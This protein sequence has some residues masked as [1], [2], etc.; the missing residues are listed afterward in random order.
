VSRPDEQAQQPIGSE[1]T[2]EST[3]PEPTDADR[4]DS[5][6]PEHDPSG[7]DLARSVAGSYR[8]DRPRKPRR[9]RRRGRP[10]SPGSQASGAYPDD[11][12]PQSLDASIDRLV[13]EHGWQTDI[14]VHA[15]FARWDQIVGVEVAQHCTP[16]RYADDELTV[17]ADSTSWA[18]QMRLLAADVVRRLNQELGDGTVRRI[19]VLGPQ[20]PS[21]RRGRRTVRGRGPRDT[22][23]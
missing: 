5:A 19:Q 2:P 18:T 16:E 23:G 3:G 10:K 11:R 17:R 1:P 22:Y 21:W 9:R 8:Q 12:D 6:A 7:L 20:A 14:A 4:P 13:T 15:V